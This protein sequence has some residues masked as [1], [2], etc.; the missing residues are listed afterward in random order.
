MS[1]AA[2]V[3]RLVRE[4][5]KRVEATLGVPVEVILYGSYARREATQ[6]SDVDILVILPQ[7]DPKVDALLGEIAWQIGFEAGLVMSVV[8]VAQGEL[9]LLRASPFFQAVQR[10]G[11][12]L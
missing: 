3:R 11:I 6:E 4:F 1:S 9:G 5:H 12:P 2:A 7:L 8:P 10:E